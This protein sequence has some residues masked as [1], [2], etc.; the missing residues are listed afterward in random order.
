MITI[1]ESAQSHFRR[2]IEQQDL[3][4]LGVRLRVVRAGTPKAD[5]ELTFCE[6]SDLTGDELELEL[7]GFSM[8]V[9]AASAPFLEQAVIDFEKSTTGGSLTIKAPR[10]K[11]TVPG[12]EAPLIE[13]IRYVIESE[14][15]PGL[16]SH[17]GRVTAESLEADGTL[18]LRFGGGCHGCGMVDVTLRDG[19]EK[20]LKARIPEVTGVRDAT[21]HST[22]DAPYVR[23]ATR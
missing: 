17:G 9:D 16:A 18:V 22:G 4:G 5:C 12:A 6:P 3:P 7:E 21:D 11:G 23:R 20:T 13:R 14:I 10:I 8:F 15:N 19:I 2:L 1:G